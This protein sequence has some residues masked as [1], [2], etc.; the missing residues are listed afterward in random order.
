LVAQVVVDIDNT[1]AASAG[2]VKEFIKRWAAVSVPLSSDLADADWISETCKQNTLRLRQEWATYMGGPRVWKYKRPWDRR[3][4]DD[5]VDIDDD[6]YYLA[7]PLSPPWTPS[8]F[9]F[10]G[11]LLQAGCKFKKSW[12]NIL[13]YVLV[14]RAEPATSYQWYKLQNEGYRLEWFGRGLQKTEMIVLVKRLAQPAIQ[15]AL[16]AGVPPLVPEHP[17]VHMEQLLRKRGWIDDTMSPETKQKIIR[18]DGPEV[19]S[20][21]LRK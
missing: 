12:D 1:S 2:R 3:D 4:D 20:L 18:R 11:L 13:K 5:D 6:G 19:R 9:E 17:L 14:N 16:A 15:N 21:A 7:K 10:L 8:E